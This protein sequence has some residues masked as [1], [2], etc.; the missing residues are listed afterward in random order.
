MTKYCLS[1]N[2]TKLEYNTIAKSYKQRRWSYTSWTYEILLT[3]LE[4]RLDWLKLLEIWTWTWYGAKKLLDRYPKLHYTWVDLSQEML[5]I[6]QNTLEWFDSSRYILHE[7]D[8]LE[9]ECSQQF[10][11][12]ISNSVIHF[13]DYEKTISKM[14][15]LMISN[16]KYCIV[17]R[18]NDNRFKIKQRRITNV[19]QSWNDSLSYKEIEILFEKKWLTRKTHKQRRE[20]TFMMQLITNA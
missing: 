3:H 19:L 9:R 16:W 2:N 5:A 10:D 14:K 17:D 7:S 15:S 6:A 1:M 4:D 18:S 13:M 12:I 11:I 20:W 8:F